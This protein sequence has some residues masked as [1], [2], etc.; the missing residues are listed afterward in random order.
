MKCNSCGS[1][2]SF[3]GKS[4]VKCNRCGVLNEAKVE[5]VTVIEKEVVKS[6]DYSSK[7]EQVKD[8]VIALAVKNE[9]G[10]KTSGTGF[11]INDNGLLVT[12]AHVANK[13]CEK[14]IGSY[15]DD[16]VM[17]NVIYD[18]LEE[19]IDVAILK[20]TS[21]IDTKPLNIVSNDSVKTGNEC[22][23]YGNTKG[24]GLQFVKGNISSDSINDTY[25][26]RVN[27]DIMSGNSGGP[28][29]DSNSNVIGIT[30]KSLAEGSGHGIV[31][32]SDK[33]LDILKS[34]EGVI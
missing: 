14:I 32:K 11:F 13:L 19:D 15:K 22:F 6:E 16:P 23:T 8:S 18:G 31:I 5:K 12:N 29:F 7:V 30:T 1:P 3:N 10:E 4:Q 27:L 26:L 28:L 20:P 34:I 25:F 24:N 2:L 9:F 33:L 17:F 21:N